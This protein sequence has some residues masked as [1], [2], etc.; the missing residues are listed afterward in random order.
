MCK[1]EQGNMQEIKSQNPQPI[2]VRSEA[3]VY[4]AQGKHLLLT[5]SGCASKLL[6]SEQYLRGVARNAA[7]AAGATVLQ[8]FSHKFSPQGITVLVVLAESHASLHTY[9]ESGV[10]FWDCFTCGHTCKPDR[11]AQVLIDTLIPTHIDK[12][13]ILRSG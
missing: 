8:V 13:I 9:P 2:E 5:L 10:V 4:E 12:Q 3:P 7:I 6:D 1:Q 11:S